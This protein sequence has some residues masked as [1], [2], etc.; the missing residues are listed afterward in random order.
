M[1]GDAKLFVLLRGQVDNN[2]PV[3]ARIPGIRQKRIDPARIDR[4]VIAHHHDRRA[5]IFFA[6]FA[7]ILQRLFQV[8][9]RLQRALAGQLDRRAICHG[10]G[11]G[12]PQFDDIDASGR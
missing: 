8:L 9:P 3:N 11:K 2:Q 12:H 10:V 6:Q 1:R 7:G 5:V 4:V